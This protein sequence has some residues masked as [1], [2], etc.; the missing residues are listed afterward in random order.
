MLSTG[1]Y[2]TATATAQSSAVTLYVMTT[3]TI[4]CAY[5]VGVSPIMHEDSRFLHA[6]GLKIHC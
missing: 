5:R 2:C 6:D 1:F 4:T 3:I